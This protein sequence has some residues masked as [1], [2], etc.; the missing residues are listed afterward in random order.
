MKNWAD[1][2]KKKIAFRR[3]SDLTDECV[4][5]LDVIA[6]QLAIKTKA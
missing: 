1:K 2:I 3:Q 6:E 4:I 5:D